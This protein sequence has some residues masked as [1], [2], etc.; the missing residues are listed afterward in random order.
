MKNITT[1]FI[2]EDTRKNTRISTKLSHI[3]KVKFYI[4]QPSPIER[5]LKIM[6][7]SLIAVIV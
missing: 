7:K 1:N 4:L 5:Q 3:I 2:I 6:E